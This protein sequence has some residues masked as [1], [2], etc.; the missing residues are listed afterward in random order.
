MVVDDRPM[1]V[2]PKR[3]RPLGKYALESRPKLFGG[4]I[5]EYVQVLNSQSL[6]HRIV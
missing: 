1:S 6:P 2:M 5:E 3:K 4:S